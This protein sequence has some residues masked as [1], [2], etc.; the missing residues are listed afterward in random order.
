VPVV[1]VVV[2][3]EEA[4]LA[5]DALW[6]AEPSA[7]GEEVQPDGTVVLT[8]D[9]VDVDLVA[10]PW[11][12]TVV[13]VDDEAS[14]DAWRAWAAPVRAGARIV[15]HPAW[16]PLDA[17]S[18]DD[19]V[20]SLDP[21]RTFGSG[22]HASTRL[23]VAAVEAHL[24]AGDRVLD[25]GAGSGVLAVVAARLGAAS[26]RAIDIDPSSPAVTQANAKRNA[27][28]EVVRASTEPL[29]A[30]TGTYDLVLANIGVRVLAELAVDLWEHVRT[31]GLLV[32]AGLLE[33]QVDPLLAAAYPV[34]VE[35]ERRSAEGWTAVVLRRGDATG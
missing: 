35:V 26:V 21:G 27:V 8:A 30:V 16:L 20:V 13:E 25:V 7:V 9:V 19:V 3:A 29:Q 32:L 31:G 34:A 33:P 23:V 5:A 28:G 10:G 1:R 15:L 24:R 18:A 4:E 11:P 17:V 6:Q 2:A 12:V 14:L 22:S